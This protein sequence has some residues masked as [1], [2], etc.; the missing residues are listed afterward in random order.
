[1]VVAAGHAEDGL[2]LEAVVGSGVVDKKVL[3]RP[4]GIYFLILT[5]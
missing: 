1:M 5:S 2:V 3:F 4:E